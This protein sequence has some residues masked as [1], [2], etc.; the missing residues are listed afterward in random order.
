MQPPQTALDDLMDLL[1]VA[2]PPGQETPVAALLR[3]KL[4]A[5]GVPPA[6][7]AHDDAQSQSEYGGDCGNLIVRIAG[8]APGLPRMF[9]AHMDTV[10]LAVGA[11]P[12]LERDRGRIVNAAEGCALGGDNRTGCAL[13]LHAARTLAA[14]EGRHVP[15]VLVFFVQEE[16][17]LVGARGLDVS[18]LGDPPPALAFN[19]DGDAPDEIVTRVTGTE[20]FNIRVEGRAAH[21]GS[22]PQAGVSAAIVAARALAELHEQGWHGRIEK[23]EGTGS[24]NAGTIAGGTGS[25]VVMPRLDLLAEARSH[26]PAFRKSI[27]GAW[28]AAFERSAAAVA[29]AAGERGRVSFSPGPAYEA[30]ALAD[31][32]PVVR[33]A[34][35]A[36]ER[37]GVS[38]RCVSNDGGMD[39]NWTNAKGI[40][41]VTLGGGQREVHTANEWIDLAEFARACRIAEEL[42][43]GCAAR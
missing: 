32:A 20:R 21:A 24:A 1:A 10:P 16:V 40:P 36:A 5:L 38:A 4:G 19:F 7:I 15:V 14:L 39:G 37:A 42:A 17:G 2:A 11:K 31:D 43:R 13:V 29:N 23:R 8:T 12:K 9:S 25:N 18:R 28:E 34:L 30:V 22:Q 35:A 6:S 26:S 33:E 3:E 27:R 41:T